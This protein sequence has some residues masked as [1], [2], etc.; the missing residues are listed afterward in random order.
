MALPLSQLPVEIL[1]EVRER[2]WTAFL[3]FLVISFTVLGLG[4]V[5][6][7]KYK[8]EVVIFVD[9]SNI[10]QPLMEGSAVTTEVSDTTSAA[11]EMLLTRKVLE[12]AAEDR[13][14]FSDS[15]QV[16][17][18]TMD[19]RI[20]ALRSGLY[21]QPRGGNY[22]SIGYESTSQMEAFRVAQKLA[23]LF[24]EE[25]NDRKRS[26]SRSAYDFID[27]QVKSYERQLAEVERRLQVFLSENVDG[28]EGDANA[29]MA[30]LRGQI[31]L[32]QLEREQ[33]VTR[34]QSLAQQLNE[35]SPTIRR[36]QTADEYADRIASLEEQLDSL[37][38]RYLDTYPDIVILREQIAELRRQRTRAMA[39]GGAGTVISDDVDNPLYQELR[40]S[41]A[42]A[43]TEIETIDT[44]ISSLQRLMVQQTARMERIQGNKAE[45]AELTRDMQ[46]NRQIYDDLLKRRERA[47]VSMHL[48]IEGQGL[49]FRINEAAQ[50]PT[51]PSGPKFSMFA[52]AGLVL[53]ILAPFGSVAGLL[54]I[55]PRVRAK[56][57]LD[58]EIG[59][60]VL[61]E[62]PYVRTPFEKRRDRRLTNL[63]VF[64]SLVTA[65]V[66]IVI[67]VASGV[68]YF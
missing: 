24:I 66:Y 10:I 58:E 44:R 36:E 17:P 48:D 1:R 13:D 56:E 43:R 34:V 3:M 21:V 65:V 6:P 39:D 18:E 15:G 50:Y 63:V 7:Y 61:I 42:R 55:D 29:R 11:R 47:R 8:S 64:C 46:V 4:F 31:E 68:G 20:G 26:E 45:Y 22:F 33:L 37:R 62:I 5:W 19:R 35:I 52:M 53:G 59:L 67:A 57:Q 49:K 40:T 2:K 25:S 23:Q 16:S 41:L 12:A 9:D 28:T 51:S 27:N 54:Q 32:A 30:T 60:P 14:I 38:L